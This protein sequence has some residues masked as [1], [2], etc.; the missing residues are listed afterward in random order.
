MTFYSGLDDNLDPNEKILASKFSKDPR[1]RTALEKNSAT[2]DMSRAVGAGY[3]GKTQDWWGIP[4][5][6][7]AHQVQ[8]MRN[9]ANQ[10]IRIQ[11]NPWINYV[12]ESQSNIGGQGMGGGPWYGGGYLNP[13]QTMVAAGGYMAPV[14]STMGGR[15]W[16]ENL[17]SIVGPLMIHGATQLSNYLYKKGKKY[18]EGSGMDYPLSSQERKAIT[19]PS[20]LLQR[21]VAGV[22]QAD[23]DILNSHSSGEFWNK[24]SRH[25]A[26]L[27]A[28]RVGE[29][30]GGGGKYNKKYRPRVNDLASRVVEAE[31]SGSGMINPLAYKKIMNN[32]YDE[33]ED[34]VD[35]L[36]LGDVVKPIIETAV[37]KGPI[38][39]GM[40]SDEKQA[41][42]NLIAEANKDDLGQPATREAFRTGPYQYIDLKNVFRK[43]SQ[44]EH[45]RNLAGR[46][47][48][49]VVEQLPKRL[50]DFA[51]SG[52]DKIVDRMPESHLKNIASQH[53]DTIKKVARHSTEKLAKHVGERAGE[54]IKSLADAS[55][56]GT[57][58]MR[59]KGYGAR[60]HP[61]GGQKKNWVVKL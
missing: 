39:K 5:I 19:S 54:H 1:P 32:R 53:K 2:Q 12:G 4:R 41:T 11:D 22:G 50:G 10:N 59:R 30:V 29:G 43:A 3:D 49:H 38:G 25:G 60:S 15:Q 37:E 46:V 8:N 47:R 33:P 42:L 14:Q 57:G 31:L 36:R 7:V 52:V 35:Q 16:A 34:R 58:K 55:T 40:N 61:Y 21:D 56:S 28:E 18:A 44:S 6:S 13:P 51:E 45:V 48:D 20:A 17:A 27:I 26:N 23:E 9:A 24:L